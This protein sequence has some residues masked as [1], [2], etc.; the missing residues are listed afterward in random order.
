MVFKRIGQALARK[1]K[2]EREK[3]FWRILFLF[4][5]SINIKVYP[6]DFKDYSLKG[7]LLAIIE[8]V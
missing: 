6:V 8:H 7:K 5:L 4:P 3:L 1:R 2:R